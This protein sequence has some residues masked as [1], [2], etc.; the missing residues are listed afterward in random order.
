MSS[1]GNSS[2]LLGLIDDRQLFSIFSS[3][4]LNAVLPFNS[5]RSSTFAIRFK[6]PSLLSNLWIS[7]SDWSFVDPLYEKSMSKLAVAEA[8]PEPPIKRNDLAIELIS[9]SV[10]GALQVLVGQVSVDQSSVLVIGYYVCGSCRPWTTELTT[11]HSLWIR[12]RRYVDKSMQEETE[13][14]IGWSCSM[15]LIKSCCSVHRRRLKV[16][17]RTH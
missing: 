13:R 8:Y 11:K 5:A 10:G 17:S 4:C 6:K 15:T 3:Y 14:P 9:G 7:A 2:Q 16:N 12:S 1:L